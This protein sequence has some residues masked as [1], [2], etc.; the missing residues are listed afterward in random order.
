MDQLI[1]HIGVGFVRSERYDHFVVA[2]Q[3][4]HV[5]DRSGGFAQVFPQQPDGEVAQPFPLT[6]ERNQVP[7]PPLNSGRVVTETFECRLMRK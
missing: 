7:H 6:D 3:L 2:K 1:R 4:D 5:V